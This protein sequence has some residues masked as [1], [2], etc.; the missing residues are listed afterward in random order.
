VVGDLCR[1]TLRI[2]VVAA[3][4]NSLLSGAALSQTLT[5]K[6][7]E[8]ALSLI[9]LASYL[10]VVGPVP[11]KIAWRGYV[12]SVLQRSRTALVASLVL[13]LAWAIW[14]VPLFLIEGNISARARGW[15][16]GILALPDRTAPAVRTPDMGCGQHTAEHVRSDPHAL[17][18]ELRRGAHY[19]SAVG[20]EPTCV[21][22]HFQ[23]GGSGRLLGTSDADQARLTGGQPGRVSDAERQFNQ[24][25]GYHLIRWCCA[26]RTC[27]CLPRS[28]SQRY[29]SGTAWNLLRRPRGRLPRFVYCIDV[30]RKV[31]PVFVTVAVDPCT[32]VGIWGFR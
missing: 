6:C 22:D 14:H 29:S 2:R 3:V 27:V 30:P 13:G 9:V 12:L 19:A 28:L 8:S 25:F 16:G 10:F 15:L 7:P 23:S 31:P 32:N 5:L 21:L 24:R 26:R 11:E 4:L 17:L 20:R 1:T 18:G